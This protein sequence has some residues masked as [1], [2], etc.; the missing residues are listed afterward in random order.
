MNHSTVSRIAWSIGVNSKSGKCF[1]SLS[2]DAVFLSCPS[3][4]VVSK[5]IFPCV[6][7]EFCAQ[8][9][10]A[11]ANLRGRESMFPPLRPQT[12]FL[13][14]LNTHP[15]KLTSKPKHDATIFAASAIETS[16]SSPGASVI[17]SVASVLNKYQIISLAKSLL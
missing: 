8:E 10:V 16:P 7:W 5:T 2:L 12:S 1:R 15:P 17:S 4:L 13:V 14:F 11:S 9:G 3:G 6:L